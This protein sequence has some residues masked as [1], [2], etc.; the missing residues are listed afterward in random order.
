MIAIL[1]E[2]K[3]VAVWDELLDNQ[4]LPPAIQHFN[5]FLQDSTTVLIERQLEYLLN[6]D[7]LKENFK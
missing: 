2:Y 3:P 6:Q 7:L 1:I 5:R 4:R